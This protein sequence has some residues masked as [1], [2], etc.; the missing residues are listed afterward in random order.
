MSHE[1]YMDEMMVGIDVVHDG[2]I[3]HAGAKR[4]GDVGRKGVCIVEGVLSELNREI[5]ALD[6]RVSEEDVDD[7]REGVHL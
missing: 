6:R 1:I 2:V 5:P 7:G 4:R 3:R